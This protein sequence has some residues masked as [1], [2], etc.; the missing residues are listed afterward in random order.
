[1]RSIVLPALFATIAV[2]IWMTIS[3][4]VIPWHAHEIKPIPES[5]ITQLTT[6]LTEKGIYNY[7]G[8]PAE[9]T[10]AAM[11]EMVEKYRRGPIVSFMV[12]NPEGTELMRPGQF[13]IMFFMIFAAAL[14][15]AYLLTRTLH[16]KTTFSQRVIFV[17]LMGVFAALLGPLTDWNWWMYPTSYSV[18]VAV[19]MVITWLIGGF[20]L[21][22][23]IRP[24]PAPIVGY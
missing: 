13:I 20:V 14:I 12:Y 10:D 23:R 19:D 7:P 21:A 18:G 11:N 6:G 8:Y 2:Y 22:W 5:A 17:T 16:Y 4:T 3:W 9:D 15:A 1:M 24:E